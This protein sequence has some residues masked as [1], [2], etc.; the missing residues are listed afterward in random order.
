MAKKKLK[1]SEICS[2]YSKLRSRVRFLTKVL[3]S[4]I[5]AS[6]ISPNQARIEL[7]KLDQRLFNTMTAELLREMLIAECYTPDPRQETE[8]VVLPRL[9]RFALSVEG[10]VKRFFHHL[11]YASVLHSRPPDCDDKEEVPESFLLLCFCGKDLEERCVLKPSEMHMQCWSL[12]SVLCKAVHK[13][14]A[15]VMKLLSFA[16]QG[17]MHYGY[18]LVPILE[19]QYS[20]D[21][22]DV[23]VASLKMSPRAVQPKSGKGIRILYAPFSCKQQEYS[24]LASIIAEIKERVDRESKK[25]IPVFNQL[26][27]IPLEAYEQFLSNLWASIANESNPHLVLSG[28]R[29]KVV[30]DVAALNCTGLRSFSFV[31]E[32]KTE[33]TWCVYP[34]V[35]INFFWDKGNHRRYSSATIEQDGT[36]SDFDIYSWPSVLQKALWCII[37]DAY[38]EIVLPRKSESNEEQSARNRKE[39]E[40]RKYRKRRRSGDAVPV[41]P[42]FRKL[43]EGWQASPE[44]IQRSIDVVGHAPPEGKTF[45]DEFSRNFPDFE[46]PTVQPKNLWDRH[47]KLPPIL[48]YKESS[49]LGLLEDIST[50][51][52][53]PES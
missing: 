28:G 10:N 48:V 43:A 52:N 49:L 7:Q 53:S 25:T 11:L 18:Q 6:T 3:R 9:L 37:F 27:S 47:Q 19:V 16:V 35:H 2:D 44:K 8:K 24:A 46:N 20:D 4:E 23:L 31:R 40:R 1:P 14:D 15:E 21:Q 5:K 39:V 22:F 26:E 38:A 32:D 33:G 30:I 34:R 36:V 51:A 17:L 41:H 45:V 13:G 29:D 12:I 42:F 50:F